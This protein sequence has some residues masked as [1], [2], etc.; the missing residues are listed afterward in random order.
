[1]EREKVLN[2]FDEKLG[3]GLP[4]GSNILIMG[5]PGA[6]KTTF[7]YHFL[8]QGMKE[9]QKC[10]FITTEKPPAAVKEALGGSVAIVDAYSWKVGKESAIQQISDLNSLNIE[11]TK[12]MQGFEKAGRVVFDSPSS[13]F[14]YI[15][16]PLIVKFLAIMA[17]K[18]R[19]GGH[20]G[21]LVLEEG[22]QD[23]KYITIINS[24]C[25]GMIQFRADDERAMKITRLEATDHFKD[26]IKFDIEDKK[27][28]IK[29]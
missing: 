22:V 16:P 13:L 29:P 9:G 1:M 18:V 3:G 4:R 15:P 27:I 11:I 2:G 19:N 14:L 12:A 17:A 5:P 7:S 8:K 21:L 20:V 28:V 26:W 25:D 6:G 23:D 24:L 10:L